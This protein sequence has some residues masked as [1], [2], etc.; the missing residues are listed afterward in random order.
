MNLVLRTPKNMAKM[1]EKIPEKHEEPGLDRWLASAP[2]LLVCQASSRMPPAKD[3]LAHLFLP[4]LGRVW[5][6]G[7]HFM[8]HCMPL[9][10]DQLV[11]LNLQYF[12]YEQ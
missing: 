12:V 3:L 8:G 6:L 5:V 9:L 4:S 2:R 7:K 11:T 10:I 1:G